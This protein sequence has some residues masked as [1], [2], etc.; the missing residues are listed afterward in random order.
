MIRLGLNDQQL[1]TL[2]FT[3]SPLMHVTEA[4]IR[5]QQRPHQPPAWLPRRWA[6]VSPG[7]RTLLLDLIDPSTHSIPDFLLPLTDQYRPSTEFEL[8]AL[9]ATPLADLRA[10]LRLTYRLGP[11]DEVFA[12]RMGVVPAVADRWRKAPSELVA[13]AW[14]GQSGPLL[15]AA[16]QALAEVWEVVL[17]PT[18]PVIRSVTE[19]DVMHRLH[20]VRSAGMSSAALELVDGEAWDGRAAQLESPLELDLTR[21]HHRIVLAPSTL[22]ERGRAVIISGDNLLIGYP[23]RGRGVISGPH[24]TGRAPKES[25]SE[26]LGTR[27]R[28]IAA[29]EVPQPG[30][31]LAVRLGLSKATVS[32]HLGRLHSSG[33]VD[34]GRHGREVYYARTPAG[35]ALTTPLRDAGPTPS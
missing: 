2:R 14:A 12:D 5:I 35:E 19:T 27:H 26:G 11:V 3:V 1:S 33:L 22:I 34:R 18:W 20:L 7:S 21:L 17:A 15:D 8:A 9:A 4:V 30:H 10:Q 25:P 16:Q 28:L 13:A 29:L 31:S 23:C 24:A 32:Y 6:Q